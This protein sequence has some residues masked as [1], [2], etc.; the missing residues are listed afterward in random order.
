MYVY[1]N[2]FEGWVEL[3]V[4][5]FITLYLIVEPLAGVELIIY[6]LR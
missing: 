6:S 2:Q 4:I 3:L 5:Q 1:I